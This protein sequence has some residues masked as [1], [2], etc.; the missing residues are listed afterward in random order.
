MALLAAGWIASDAVGLVA[1][2]LRSVLMW[3]LLGLA[4]LALRPRGSQPAADWLWLLGAAILAAAWIALG[5][6]VA[7]IL[8]VVLIG[9]T[10]VRLQPPGPSRQALLCATLATALLGLFHSAE[11]SLPAVWWFS[12]AAGGLLGRMGGWI[13]GQPLRVGATFGGVNQLVSMLAFFAAWLIFGGRP[14]MRRAVYAA[15]AVGLAHLAYLLVLAQTHKLLAALPDYVLPPESENDRLGIWTWSNA[16]HKALPWDLPALAALAHG[17]VAAAM[18]RWARW[19]A[20][21][22]GAGGASGTRLGALPA[23][24]RKARQAGRGFAG[25]DGLPHAQLRVAAL[26]VLWAVLV[27]FVPGKVDL[28]GKTIVAYE[29]GYLNWVRPTHDVFYSQWSHL[30]GL[31]PDFIESLGGQLVHSEDLSAADLRRADVVLLIHP[32]QPWP[33]DRLRRLLDYV[34]QGGALMLV[35]E[36]RVFDPQRD[37]RSSFAELLRHTAIAVRDDTAWPP[38]DYWEN[39][40]RA[41]AHP[42]TAGL[43]GPRNRFHLVLASSIELAFGARPVLVGRYGLSEPGSDAAASGTYQF[44]P[45]ERL[46]DLVLAAEQR[47]GRGRVFVLGDTAPLSCEGLARAWQFLGRVLAHLAGNGLDPYALWRQLAAAAS[48]LGLVGLLCWRPD[49]RSLAVLAVVLPLVLGAARLATYWSWRVLPDGS[50][51][52]PNNLAF[53]DAAHLEAYSEDV[54]NSFGLG[55]FL[56]TLARN[57]YLPLV[58]YDEPLG[59]DRLWGTRLGRAG[60]LVSIAPAEHFSRDERQAVRE[61]LAAGGTLISM[62]GAEQAG[63]TNDLLA[64]YGLRVPP[65]PLPPQPPV[66]EPEPMGSVL[67]PF[68]VEGD[69]IH[70]VQLYAGWPIEASGQ[71]WEALATGRDGQPVVLSQPGPAGKAPGRVVL[72]GD[73]YLAVNENVQ[74]G[75]EQAPANEAFWRWLIGQVTPREQ[76]IPPPQKSPPTGSG[77][78]GAGAGAGSD[79]PRGHLGESPASGAVLPEPRPELQLPGEPPLFEP[80]A[81]PL[82]V[83]DEPSSLR[84]V[85]VEPRAP[86]GPGAA[87]AHQMPLAPNADE[88]PALPEPDQRPA[89]PKADEGV[90]P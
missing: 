88:Q 76:W 51:A 78:A 53:I 60:L 33:E 35:A 75:D 9:T 5:E 40:L 86:G 79:S 42:V 26:A 65:S 80:P 59:L 8:A 10:L 45:G 56:R 19:E 74:S 34:R 90:Q 44:D 70:Y 84:G 69:Q 41:L 22:L 14:R 52:E 6:A 30:Y 16:L 32:D 82:P 25:E 20:A 21:Q 17:L 31:L 73:T 4:G 23:S 71:R 11:S 49:L 66:R 15:L 7:G 28:S 64:E 43:A 38:A 89:R 68:L 2:P 29:Q 46:G 18:L 48:L 47:L 77:S 72:I 85:S 54:W 81:E 61:L 24:V 58:L 87:D 12:E 62:C 50:K 37:S 55:S 63:P 1:R 39:D 13:A 67:A 27:G 36:P 3:L 57:G 83:P